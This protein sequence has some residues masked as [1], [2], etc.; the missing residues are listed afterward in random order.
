[1]G[2]DTILVRRS[3]G[4]ASGAMTHAVVTDLRQVGDRLL[5]A[6]PARRP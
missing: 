3:D 5:R 2:M 4:D 6:E 1:L